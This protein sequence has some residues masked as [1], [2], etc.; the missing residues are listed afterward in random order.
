MVAVI[1]LSKL[2]LLLQDLI[3]KK[4]FFKYFD[5]EFEMDK[6]KR[7]LKFSK[8]LVIIEDSREMIFDYDR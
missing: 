6:F 8:K 5:T 3:S 1:F 2:Y 4:Q 7:K